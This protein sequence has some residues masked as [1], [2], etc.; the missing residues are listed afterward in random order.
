MGRKKPATGD[1]DQIGGTFHYAF[2]FSHFNRLLPY[3]EERIDTILRLQ[4][5]DGY[6][7]PDNHLWLTFDA[8]YL[9]TRTSRYCKHR[10]AEVV[11]LVRRVMRLLMRD[12]FS[13][14]GRV[15]AFSGELPVHSLTAA[16]SAAAEAQIFLGHREVLTDRPLR[17]VLDR[18][19]FI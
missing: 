17:L 10:Y 19:P 4:Q 9:L 16:V 11:A 3:P 14:E 15:K 1:W 2:I 5:P 12:V 6:W 18:R 8:M 7:S 13:A